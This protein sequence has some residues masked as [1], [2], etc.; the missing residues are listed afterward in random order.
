MTPSQQCFTLVTAFEGLFLK[1]YEDDSTP[2]VCTIGYG[3]TVNDDGSKIR[4]EQVCSEG[5]AL[6]WLGE[7]LEHEGWHFI[8]AWVTQSL[9]Q[10]EFDALT[11]FIYNC[12]C[13]TFKRKVLPYVNAG[14]MQS[15]AN[16]MR[17]CNSAGGAPLAGLIRRREAET[18]L[19]LGNI[20]GMTAALDG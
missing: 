5:Q 1:A 18:C 7:D 15:A 8:D 2:P 4:M 3:R 17:T 6:S 13:G 14:D 19:L 9:K 20:S 10:N 12:G 11:S 16:A